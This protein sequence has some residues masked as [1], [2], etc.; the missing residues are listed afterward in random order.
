MLGLLTIST[1]KLRFVALS[2]LLML[3]KNCK[4]LYMGLVFVV[5]FVFLDLLFVSCNFVFA[6]NS[7]EM[8]SATH[9]YH[10]VPRKFV[11]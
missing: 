4:V 10:N 9:D 2:K 8:L 7:I 5:F 11:Y 3:I 1:I 6:T